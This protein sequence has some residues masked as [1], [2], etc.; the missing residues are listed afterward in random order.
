MGMKLRSWLCVAALLFVAAGWSQGAE[1]DWADSDAA[2]EQVEAPRPM[3]DDGDDCVPGDDCDSCFSDG[4]DSCLAPVGVPW[5]AFN[6]NLTPGF[7]FTAGLLLLEPGADNLGFATTTT[8]L[9][10][11][12]PQWAVHAL[13][14]DYQPGFNVGARYA[15]ASGN[16]LRVGWDHLRT[17][18]ST[19]AAV[20]NLNTQWISPFSQTG[21][22]TSESPNQ[23]GI[24]HLK[25]AE[26]RVEFDY[27]MTN[28]DVGQTVSMGPNTQIRMFAGLS[29]VRLRQQ[30]FS[31]FYNNPNVVPVPPVVA[32][33]DPTLQ[34]VSLDNK[35]NYTGF[36]PRLGLNTAFNL[37]RGF[38]FVGEVS[39]A[40]FA[41]RMQPAEYSFAGVFDN[42][43]DSEQI[44]SQRVSQ[45]VYAS[46]A[47]L[48]AGY[49]RAMRN[50]SLLKLESGFKAAVFVD[51]FATYETSTNVLPL[52]IGSLS[53]NSM[54]H[55]PSNF[56]LNGLYASCSLQW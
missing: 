23:V 35:T 48:G 16:D 9:P 42:A 45:V 19:F 2:E 53:T 14:P 17:S 4:C 29:Y 20:D 25:S 8:F 36:G 50:G 18:D 3:R 21:P 43:L 1:P 49:T 13:D 39:G 31:K 22:S 32:I 33:P 24:F 47:K 46:D 41:G 6:P 37:T 27:D 44:S 7:E 5:A 12:N 10:L 26:G 30:L 54:R 52:D 51:P 55:T 15:F 28:L 34:Y 38:H 11:Q 56:T 40:I